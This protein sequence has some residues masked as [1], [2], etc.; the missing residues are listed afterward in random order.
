TTTT[1]IRSSP[2][3]AVGNTNAVK[4]E[5]S[6]LSSSLNNNNPLVPPPTPIFATFD[7][8]PP[9]DS[10]SSFGIVDEDSNDTNS[11]VG[12]NSNDP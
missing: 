11:G 6:S 9:L 1:T 2:A 8:L 5:P 3:I 7:S 4:Q 12:N 10:L